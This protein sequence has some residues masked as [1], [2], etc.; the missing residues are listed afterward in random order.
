[1]KE[2][3]HTSPDAVS[4][5]RSVQTSAQCDRDDPP[6]SLLALFMNVAAVVRFARTASSS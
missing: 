5:C 2:V 3:Q 1:V 6:C 4:S